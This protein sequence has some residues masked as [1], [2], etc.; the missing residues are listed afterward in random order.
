MFEDCKIHSQN[1][2]GI[3]AEIGGVG[4][5]CTGSGGGSA[6]GG[7]S[8]GGKRGGSSSVVGAVWEEV[9]SHVE[10][11]GFGIDKGCDFGGLCTA[12]D[13]GGGRTDDGFRG[14]RRVDKVE[15]HEGLKRFTQCF[16]GAGGT[17]ED[18]VHFLREDPIKEEKG[19]NLD[20][21]GGDLVDKVVGVS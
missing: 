7:S 9:K 15:K 10:K 12:A 13:V 5:A 20:R 18:E 6:P 19:L 16:A 14:T 17:V 2:K 4:H 8:D 21:R 3:I 1:W 11:G